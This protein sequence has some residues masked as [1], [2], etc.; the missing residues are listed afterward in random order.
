MFYLVIGQVCVVDALF[1]KKDRVHMEDALLDL[2][3]QIGTFNVSHPL[4]F[5]L[6]SLIYA[7]E[8]VQ[9]SDVWA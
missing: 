4:I 8:L 7:A 9:F 1:L 6:L 3:F 2:L 5:F